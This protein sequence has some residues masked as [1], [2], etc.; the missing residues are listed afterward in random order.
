[1]N[2]IHQIFFTALLTNVSTYQGWLKWICSSCTLN[3]EENILCKNFL[4]ERSPI[5]SFS[6]QMK[7]LYLI[8]LRCF[9]I[10]QEGHD[11]PS[12]G[13]W[14]KDI[15]KIFTF[16]IIKLPAFEG[17]SLN[18]LQTHLCSTLYSIRKHSPY[19]PFIHLITVGEKIAKEYI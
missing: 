11:G 10:F 14:R 18:T 5:H 12:W 15:N 2:H 7:I 1:M 17:V 9:E 13:R 8:V 3:R 19:K 16:Y 4:T 6:S